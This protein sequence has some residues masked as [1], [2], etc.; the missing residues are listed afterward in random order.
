MKNLLIFS[1][2]A[3]MM[4][5]SC[6]IATLN[7]LDDGHKDVPEMGTVTFSLSGGDDAL[8]TRSTTQAAESAVSN[9]QILVFN[10]G[11]NLVSYAASS[12]NTVSASVPLNT[13]GHSVY[14]VTNVS[15]DLSSCSSPSNLTSRMSYLKDNSLDKL[16]MIGHVDNQTFTSGSTV[17]VEVRRFA[18]KVEIDEIVSAFTAAAHRAQEF[19]IKSIFLINV[20]GS[21]PYSQVS[22]AG[23]W[24]NQLRYVSGDCNA[25]VSDMFQT[26]VT[27]QTSSGSVTPYTTKH[28]FY[29]YSNPTTTDTHGGT[30]SPRRTRLVVETMLGGT[31]YYYPIDIVGNGNTLDVNTS[32]TVTKLTVTGPGVDNP[33]D[34]L[35]TGSVSFN[36][37]IK[38][39]E[40]GFSKTVTY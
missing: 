19:K 20:N 25:L 32:Y 16:Q 36:V 38:N 28:Y 31:T 15:D 8:M 21:C 14:A 11:G 18:A 35:N 6:D 10:S 22:A 29:C 33:D 34:P 37:T 24:Y 40:T 12:S 39:W 3:A 5:I 7:N 26:P 30:F 27:V 17:S 13:A 4:F 9:L 1:A 2:A 23:T